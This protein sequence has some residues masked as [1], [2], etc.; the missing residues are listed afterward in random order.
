MVRLSKWFEVYAK[1][2]RND[3]VISTQLRGSNIHDVSWRANLLTLL[4]FLSN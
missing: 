4:I 3:L 1:Q 2:L